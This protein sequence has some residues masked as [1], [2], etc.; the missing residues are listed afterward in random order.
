MLITTQGFRAFNEYDFS[1]TLAAQIKKIQD[2]VGLIIKS[3]NSADISKLSDKYKILPLTFYPEQITLTIESAEIP[4]EYFPQS[5][6]VERGEHYKKDVI[7]FHL[8]FS[9]DK[10]LLKCAPSPRILQ[11]EEIDIIDNDIVFEVIKFSDETGPITQE[12]EKVIKF[13]LSQSEYLNR[14]IEQYNSNI[15][16][17]IS[18]AEQK[19]NIEISK[20]EDFFKQLGIPKKEE[21]KN[22]SQVIEKSSNL[23]EKKLTEFDVFICHASEDKDFV[24]ILAQS[25]KDAGFSVWYDSFVVGWGD[26]LRPTI[27]N[28]LKNSRYGIVIFSKAFLSKKK[29]TE[30]ELNGLFSK[31]KNGKNVILPIWHNITREDIS[32]YSLTFADRIAKKSD[33]INEIILELK[34][35]LESKR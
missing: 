14:Q 16:K 29:W 22:N 8:P 15:D 24:N 12:K 35:I 27:D 1:S 34:T 18:E 2:E 17:A 31:E 4:A 10:S 7:R 11:T 13:L 21:F 5:Y 9:G 25:L 6:W 26:D 33:N 19:T 23:T 30:Y 32:Q 28:G 3:G 20:D